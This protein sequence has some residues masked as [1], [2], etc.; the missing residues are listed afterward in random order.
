MGAEWEDA[1]KKAKRREK[2]KQD[3]KETKRRS[4]CP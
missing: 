2:L 3:V 1:A 4:L